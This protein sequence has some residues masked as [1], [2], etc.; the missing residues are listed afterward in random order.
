MKLWTKTLTGLFFGIAV[1]FTFPAVRAGGLPPRC[2]KEDGCYLRPKPCGLETQY[3][4]D[5]ETCFRTVD[6]TACDYIELGC[7]EP[8]VITGGCLPEMPGP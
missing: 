5:S 7:G 4:E 3:V 1:G 8:I 6:T 2:E